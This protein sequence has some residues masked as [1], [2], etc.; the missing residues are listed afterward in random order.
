V[1]HDV[2]LG[3]IVVLYMDRVKLVIS[4]SRRRRSRRRR[5][6]KVQGKFG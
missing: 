1:H 4:A 6:T 2:S 3:N 5:R